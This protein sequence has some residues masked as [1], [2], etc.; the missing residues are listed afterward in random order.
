MPTTTQVPSSTTGFDPPQEW[1]VA[2]KITWTFTYVQN[3]VT[4][5]AAATA[6]FTTLAGPDS[7]RD[8][9]ADAFDACP[10][11]AGTLPNGCYSTESTDVYRTD[12]GIT[13]ARVDTE[14]GEGVV[15]TLAIVTPAHLIAV[16][17]SNDP[18][19]FVVERR[20]LP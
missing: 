5:T 19:R 2:M 3:G 13:V 7:D 14:P 15:C 20:V 8:G 9:V 18:V 4:K 10:G 16:P 1:N 11:T 12:T 6:P 17:R